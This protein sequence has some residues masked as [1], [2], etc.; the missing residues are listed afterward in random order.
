MHVTVTRRSMDVITDIGQLSSHF[1]GGLF[2]GLNEVGNV[3]VKEEQK[4]ERRRDK[5]GRLYRFRGGLHRASAAGE[6]PAVRTGRLLRSTGYRTHNH[7]Q[8]SFG[9]EVEYAKYLAEGTKRIAPRANLHRAVNNK[10]LDAGI[11]LRQNVN[12]EAKL[13]HA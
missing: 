12:R 6:V 10:S 8:M 3:F 1:K 4:L 7:L 11:I 9:Q 13:D 2:E 5:A